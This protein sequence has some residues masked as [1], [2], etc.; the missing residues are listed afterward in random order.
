MGTD[1]NAEKVR[2][3]FTNSRGML[4]ELAAEMVDDPEVAVDE[5]AAEYER[6]LPEMPYFDR[7]DAPMASSVFQ[8]DAS[9]ALYLALRRR[10]IDVHDYGR[11]MVAQLERMPL[12]ERDAPPVETWIGGFKTAGEASQQNAKAGE[13]V[14]EVLDPDPGT[15]MTWGMN[16]LS[17]AI[18]H[19]F[20]KHDAMDLVPYMCA[21]DDVVSDRVGQGLRRTGTRA[22]GAHH[23]DFRY[24]GA[25][26]EPVRLVESYPERIKVRPT[27][28]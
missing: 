9:L 28:T 26:G 24:H 22:L 25:Q 3:Y 6:M 5:A 11:R 21:S 19:E 13:F 20:G 7:P 4:L 17:C 12:P 2:A 23:C 1:G 8:C 10:G 18:C 14:Y 15:G 27:S 16:I